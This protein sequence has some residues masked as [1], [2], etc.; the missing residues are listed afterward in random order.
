L[1][2]SPI[3]QTRRDRESYLL[4]LSRKL[5]QSQSNRS[6]IMNRSRFSKVWKF[7]KMLIIRMTIIIDSSNTWANTSKCWSRSCKILWMICFKGK[8]KICVLV[9]LKKKISLRKALWVLS[10]SNSI[11]CRSNEK[12]LI[13]FSLY[14]QLI[15]ILNVI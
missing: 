10:K 9:E 7:K 8:N 2:I 14:I 11:I 4:K 6:S 12:N 15:D 5:I 3:Q 13:Q 1:I